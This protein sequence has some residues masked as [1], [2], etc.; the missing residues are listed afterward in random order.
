MS[1]PQAYRVVARWFSELEQR[2]LVS[3][4]LTLPMTLQEAW[5]IASRWAKALDDEY[6]DRHFWTVD[7]KQTEDRGGG[8]YVQLFHGRLS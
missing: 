5:K 7:L 8:S 6:A 3:D 2:W 1:D 4:E